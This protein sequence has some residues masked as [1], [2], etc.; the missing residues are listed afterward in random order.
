MTVQPLVPAHVDLRDFPFMPLE[1]SRLRDSSIVDEITGDEFR[2]AILL[3][4]ASWHQVPA[5]SL[6]KEA[7]QLSKFAG[8]GRVVAEWDKVSAGAL[9]GWVE[10]SDGRLYH[11]VIA[12]KAIE[13]WEKKQ[14]FAT[15][16]SQRKEQ[17]A[18]AAGARW[19]KKDP[20]PE[21]PPEGDDPSSGG[22]N[23]RAMPEQCASMPGALPKG[24]RQ[25]QG[26]GEGTAHRRG[27]PPAQG[28][29]ELGPWLRSLVGQEPVLVA[30]DI[31][32]IERLLA[33]DSTRAD[34]EAGIAAAMATKDFRPRR[35]QQ[36][37][38][39]IKGATKDRLEGVAKAGPRSVAKPPATPEQ[40]R[41]N[42]LAK[43]TAYFRGEWRQ[44]W[45]DEFL[46]GHPACT[47]PPDVIAE[48]RAV[49]ER[50]L[51]DAR[52]AA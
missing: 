26:Q 43:A 12:E 19:G 13:A 52:S 17:A 39:W 51:P 49:A 44:G 27:Q 32:V 30:Q 16:E 1:V 48:A 25:G 5:G 47:T 6:P 20:A 2:A 31:H 46:P 33:E 8:Y 3:W 34:V 40:D 29:D 24:N 23:A 37:V 11:P 21:T 4:C 35:W 14:E 36:L 15:R 22:K 42:R 28:T 41:R 45:P 10:C 38:G 7:R 9:Y 50:D 18:K